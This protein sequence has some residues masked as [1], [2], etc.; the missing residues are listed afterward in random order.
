MDNHLTQMLNG[1]ELVIAPGTTRSQPEA[2]RPTAMTPSSPAE[3][4]YS[5]RVNVFREVRDERRRCRRVPGRG[6]RAGMGG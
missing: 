4:P 2:S 5:F 3:M 1:S 6:D